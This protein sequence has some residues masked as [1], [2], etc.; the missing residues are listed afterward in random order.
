MQFTCRIEVDAVSDSSQ[1]GLLST[2]TI[3]ERN[4]HIYTRTYTQ[5]CAEFFGTYLHV[6]C[7]HP[8]SF[9]ILFLQEGQ[10]LTFTASQISVEVKKYV[11]KIGRNKIS[12]ESVRNTFEDSE[13]LR[14]ALHHPIKGRLIAHAHGQLVAVCVKWII[15]GR[16]N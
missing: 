6:T 5:G 3:K 7:M 9:Q 12:D 13:M 15:S 4:K 16:M 1:A 10:V 8:P 14:K 2:V 11:K